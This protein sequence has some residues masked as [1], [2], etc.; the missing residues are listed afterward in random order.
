MRQATKNREEFDMSSKVGPGL[1]TGATERGFVYFPST[2]GRFAR[3]S[4]R[5]R[6]A[7][8]YLPA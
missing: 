1:E 2:G 6:R 4:V 3:G 5:E 7:S 8:T